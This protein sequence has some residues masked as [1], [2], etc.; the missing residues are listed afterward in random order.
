MSTAPKR[1]LEPDVRDDEFELYDDAAEERRL[2]ERRKRRR[3][4]LEQLPP[5]Q[6]AEPK[7][8]GN[9]A[10][11]VPQRAATP[12][13]QNSPAEALRPPASDPADNAES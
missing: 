8:H 13:A 11:S 1:E 4:L 3:E 12:P 9:D 5:P 10:K 2:E 7:D 6:T